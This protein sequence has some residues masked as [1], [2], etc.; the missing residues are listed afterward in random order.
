ML[1]LN[2]L[3]EFAAVRDLEF[4]RALHQSKLLDSVDVLESNRPERETSP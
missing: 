1:P 4:L 3:D 2:R